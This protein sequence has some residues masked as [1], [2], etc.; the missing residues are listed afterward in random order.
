VRVAASIPLGA[1]RLDSVA[2][3]E[4]NANTTNLPSMLLCSLPPAHCYPL[5]TVDDLTTRLRGN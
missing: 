2:A 5:K 1:L 4:C 3:C